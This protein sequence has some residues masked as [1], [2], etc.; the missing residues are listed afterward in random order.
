M[1]TSPGLHHVTAI[2]SDPER[3]LAFYTNFLGLR[4]VKRTVNFDDPSA[5]HLYIGDEVAR[6][7]SLITFFAW[8]DAEPAVSGAG[9][10]VTLSLAI[11]PG[12][13]GYWADRLVD[14]GIPFA[15]G[16]DDTL[17]FHDPDGLGLELVERRWAADID[18]YDSAEVP[19]DR[20][21]RGIATATVLVTE[22]DSLAKLLT[23]ALGWQADGES[24]IGE[25]RRMRYVVPAP[26]GLG[27]SLEV[28]VHKAAQPP[29]QGA[30]SVHHIAFRAVDDAQQSALAD[31]L[32]G[33]GLKVT[34]QRDRSYFRSVYAKDTSGLLVEVATDG[35]GFFIDES[36]T[37]LG[38]S[39]KL[40]ANLEK[41][42]DD[43]LALL[44]H[45]E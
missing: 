22:P 39:L 24:T 35:P 28:L 27:T 10:V 42:R 21:P 11:P 31:R 6:P 1:T 17:A 16:I 19:E 38:R 3:M 20:S 25:F 8:P 44:P 43:I 15:V 26:A 18:G 23:Q 12:S 5:W 30:G 4:L 41:T 7:G 34:P 14:F 2:C 13:N 36:F 40:P 33:L 32:K 45:I 29:E 9:E 37:E